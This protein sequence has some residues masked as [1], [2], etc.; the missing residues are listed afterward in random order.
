M[1][2]NSK[3][4]LHVVDIIGEGP[5]EGL[6]KN[7]NSI[8]LDET[9]VPGKGAGTYDFEFKNGMPKQ[10]PFSDQTAFKDNVTT[11]IDVGVQV[12]A[13]YSET[14]NAQSKVK[15]RDY[16]RGAVVRTITDSFV[17][18]IQLIFTIPKLY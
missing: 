5:I 13:N 17:D 2:L 10:P 16:G 4:N 8:F 1:A 3:T 18:D 12:G 14:V 6:T 9:E 15:D 7:R 11:L